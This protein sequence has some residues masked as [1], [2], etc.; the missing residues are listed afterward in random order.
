[1]GDMNN[2]MTATQDRF[3][4]LCFHQQADMKLL[5]QLLNDP[6][7]TDADSV[8]AL[9]IASTRLSL[10]KVT[11]LIREMYEADS[12]LLRFDISPLTALRQCIASRNFK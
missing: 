1:M 7:F 2:T 12:S 6:F 3:N 8:H 4:L 5:N 9:K 11:E 10:H